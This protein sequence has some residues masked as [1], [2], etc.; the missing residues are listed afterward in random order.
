MARALPGPCRHPGCPAVT[1]DTYCPEHA[2][3]ASD[4]H[5][6]YDRSRKS[7]TAR[8]YGAQ[9]RRLRDMVLRREPLCRRCRAEGRR[10]IATEVDHILPL[11]QGG[12]NRWDN[13]QPLCHSCHVKKTKEENSRR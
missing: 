5:R 1:T 3:I 9:W 7:T 10:R 2:S 6:E 4:R 8:G 11:K 12:T 13:L